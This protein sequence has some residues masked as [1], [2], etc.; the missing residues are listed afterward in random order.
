MTSN[1]R[2]AFSLVELL[3]VIGIVALLIAILLPTL[4]SA[5]RSAQATADGANLR[6]IVTLAH[7][8]AGDWNQSLPYGFVIVNPA[9]KPIDTFVSGAKLDGIWADYLARW[10]GDG[11]ATSDLWQSPAAPSHSPTPQYGANPIAMPAPIAFTLRNTFHEQSE[12]AP[13]K[14]AQLYSDTA[15]FW[16]SSSYGAEA[17]GSIPAFAGYSGIDDAIG[18]GAYSGRGGKLSR[19]RHRRLEDPYAANPLLAMN[20]SIVVQDAATGPYDP[21]RDF[22]TPLSMLSHLGHVMPARFR[23]G[24]CNVATVDGAVRALAKG[25][26]LPSGRYDTEFRRF[27]LIVRPPS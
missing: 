24:R 13:A 7:G 16:S 23:G 20:E 6:Q 10:S 4:A 11:G 8:Y 5:R 1:R 14:L 22:E 21:D 15:L 19:R 3:V 18:Y 27:M 17:N 25:K 2:V 12:Y 26:L 9:G